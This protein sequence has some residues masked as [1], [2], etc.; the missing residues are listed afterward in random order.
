M[1]VESGSFTLGQTGVLQLTLAMGVKSIDFLAGSRRDGVVNNCAHQSTGHATQV[2]EDVY[3]TCTSF[4]A[5]SSTS[6]TQ[7]IPEERSV[8]HWAKK[9]NVYQ[10][11]LAVK[12]LSIVDNVVTFRCLKADSGYQVFFKAVGDELSEGAS[13]STTSSKAKGN[14]G[15]GDTHA[16]VA[17]KE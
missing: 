4:Y 9:S 10:E 15:E 6:K 7:T 1:K 3:Q 14:R 16:L 2:G 12:V 5:D 11:I 17:T 8:S 13:S